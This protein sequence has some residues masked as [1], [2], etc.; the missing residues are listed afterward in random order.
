MTFSDSQCPRAGLK[1]ISE[2][3]L[4]ISSTSFQG[5]CLVRERIGKCHLFCQPFLRERCASLMTRP[6]SHLSEKNLLAMVKRPMYSP[7]ACSVL[8]LCA[9][10]YL[11]P[12]C[13]HFRMSCDVEI[14]GK[15]DG[16]IRRMVSICW[17]QVEG[18]RAFQ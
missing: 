2:P 11:E 3:I 16:E 17:P 10:F 6:L 13:G 7:P 14:P 12:V 1:N 5:C 15:A 9:R 18:A 4:Q 8:L